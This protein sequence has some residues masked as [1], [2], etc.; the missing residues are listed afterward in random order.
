MAEKWK[1][2]AFFNDY[3]VSSFG[4][5]KNTSTNKMI[6][7]TVNNKGHVVVT[8]WK[9]GAVSNTYHVCRLVANAFVYKSKS[10]MNIIHI[11]NNYQNNCVAN[12][13]FEQLT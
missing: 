2:I 8:L 9:N 4:N 10:R 3:E 13:K 11:D 7:K 5:I 1:R 12:L 6:R